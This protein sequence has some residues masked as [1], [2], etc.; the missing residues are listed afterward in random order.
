MP[1]TID[2]DGLTTK[3]QAELITEF[4]ASLELIYGDDIN[5]EQS[6]PD[7]Q[8]MMILIQSVL[9]LEDLL[10]QIYNS[11][12]P[13][14]AVGVVLDQRVAINGIQRQAGTYTITNVTITADRPCTLFGLDQDANDPYTVADLSGT[15]WILRDSIAISMASDNV[16]VFRSELPGAVLSVANTI[17]VPVSIVLGVTAINNPT[18]YTTLGINEET[19]VDLKIRRQQSVALSSQGYLAGLL[20]ALLNIPEVT[21]AFV[22]ENTTGSTDTDSIPGHSIWVIVSGT[23]ADV[24]IANAI[25]RKRNAGC[26]MKGDQTYSVTQPDGTSFVVRWDDVTTQDVYIKFTATSLDGVNPPNVSAIRTGLPENYLPGVYEQVDINRLA[27]EVQAID[28]NTLVTVAGFSTSSTN[29]TIPNLLPSGKN[30]QFVLSSPNIIIY[31]MILSPASPS[32][33]HTGSQT[34]IGLGGYGSPSYA[35]VT[36]NSGGTIGS[37]SGLYVAGSSHPVTDIVKVFDSFSS[38]TIVSV[39]VT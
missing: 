1:N 15:R 37:Q 20:A 35:F 38:S 26:G 25:Y 32:V 16:L 6:T 18:S 19:D 30:R 4:S 8:W 21:S 14:N 11:F 5:L 2:A 24:D 10:T 23:A 31:P 36:N 3:T 12:D 22:Y 39:S 33:A 17:T 13:D 28:S 9:D 27:T 29:V 7:G 34:F